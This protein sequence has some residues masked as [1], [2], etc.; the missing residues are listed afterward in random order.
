MKAIKVAFCMLLVLSLAFSM[1]GCFSGVK[2]KVD[3]DG[4]VIIKD[5]DSEGNDVVIGG[6]KWDKSE[7]H[8][9][10][11]PKA[12]LETSLTS[13]DGTIYGFSGLKEKDAKDYIEKLKAAGFTYNSVTFEDFTYFGT[14]KD[15]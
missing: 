11:A 10:D 5:K 12:K 4:N 7:M 13:D 9:L 8:G 15:G 2:P 3:K 14:N 6:K 1:A